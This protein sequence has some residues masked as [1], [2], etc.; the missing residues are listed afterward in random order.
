MRGRTEN[1]RYPVYSTPEAAGLIIGTG[2]IGI[3]LN[4]ENLRTYISRDGGVT[5][6]EIFDKPYIFEIA[7]HGS[8]IV[9]ARDDI[10]TN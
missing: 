1:N 3:Y 7:A 5:W 6:S 8:F 10:L 2:N 4:D 9:A